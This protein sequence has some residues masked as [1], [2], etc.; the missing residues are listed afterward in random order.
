MLLA[1]TVMYATATVHWVIVLRQIS[2]IESVVATGIEAAHEASS[3][4]IWMEPTKL[5]VHNVDACQLTFLLLINVSEVK[6]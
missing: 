1:C 5:L 2:R 4:I 6:Q 3:V